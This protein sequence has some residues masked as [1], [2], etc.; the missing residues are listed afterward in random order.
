MPADVKRCADWCADEMRRIGL[1]NVRLID[2]PGNPV[3]Y[4][5]WLGR[6][7]RA[8]D[9]VLRP[10]RRAAGR[11]AESLGVAAVRG[12]DPRRRNLRARIG[13]R[14]G[15][16]LHAL[17]GD[18]GAHEAERPSAGEHEDHPRRRRR[19]RQRASRRLHP[20]PQERAQGRRRGDLRLGDVRAR[21]AVDL[22]WP[23]RPR[24]LP[25]RSARQQ[26]R[27]ALRIL[28]RRGREPRVRR[29]RSCSRR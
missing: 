16:G 19:G 9:P 25:A 23:A 1:Q 17:Q 29:S 24:V 10:L 18:R 20:R 27:P 5:D 13:R 21:R 6:A 15:P 8:D 22:L 2:T 11:S 28:R 3:V 26:H 12:D 7:G 4:G 14:Q